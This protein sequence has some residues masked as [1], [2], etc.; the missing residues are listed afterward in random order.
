MYV[1]ACMC[2]LIL[3][4]VHICACR[5]YSHTSPALVSDKSEE[6]LALRRPCPS[7]TPPPTAPPAVCKPQVGRRRC[8]DYSGIA[9]FGSNPLSHHHYHHH[10]PPQTL[11]RMCSVL[12]S[13]HHHLDTSLTYGQLLGARRSGSRTEQEEERERG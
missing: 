13:A 4:H 6:Q 10:P 11:P 7:L 1:C 8:A 12:R 9:R 5:L 2:V 3:I